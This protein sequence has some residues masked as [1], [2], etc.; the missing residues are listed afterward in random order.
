MKIDRKLILAFSA[1]FPMEIGG[2]TVAPSLSY[3]TLL[4]GLLMRTGPTAI[5][6]LPVSV[7]RRAFRDALGIFRSQ[8]AH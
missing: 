2:L 3:V 1:S 7:S 6:S 5:S 8:N 4:N